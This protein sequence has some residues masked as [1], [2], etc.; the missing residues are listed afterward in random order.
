MLSDFN[1]N[2]HSILKDI[3]NNGLHMSIES[4]DDRVGV[5]AL[6]EV[7][8]NKV[9]WSLYSNKYEGYCLEYFIPKQKEVYQNLYPVIYTK[10]RNNTFV[11][12][13]LEY[14]GSSLMR[15]IT[16]GEATKNVGAIT[17]LFHT[18]DSEWSF[19]KEWR[20]I[21]PASRHCQFLKLK[22]IYLGFRVSNSNER[23]ILK[24][25]KKLNFSVYKMNKPNGSKKITYCSLFCVKNNY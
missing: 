5:C 19:Q 22:A 14:L 25:A 24:A 1:N 20:I 6:S 2:F 16:Y 4:P 15:G 23:K 18:K 11:L 10:K 17:E 12:K 9:M 7:R 3:K 8:D 21:G 13:V